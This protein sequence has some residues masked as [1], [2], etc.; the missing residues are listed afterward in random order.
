[1]YSQIL[2]LSKLC[3]HTEMPLLPER[4]RSNEGKGSYVNGVNLS[5]PNVNY[6]GRTA[7]LTTKVA[8]YKFIQQI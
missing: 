3:I 2:S 8:F 7:P 5:T 6:S 4:L 1:M